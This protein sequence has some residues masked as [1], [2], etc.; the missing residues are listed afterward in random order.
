MKKILLILAFVAGGVL[1]AS[2]QN[3]GDK[4]PAT[5]NQPAATTPGDASAPAPTINQPATIDLNIPATATAD[6]TKASCDK[7]KCE[8]GKGCCKNKEA[9]AGDKSKKAEG[10]CCKKGKQGC[11]K[12]KEADKTEATPTAQPAPAVPATP[13]PAPTPNN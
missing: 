9:A 12:D 6:S 2:A 5:A 1:F 13:A 3:Q 4:K 7:S 8:K 11:N 10:G